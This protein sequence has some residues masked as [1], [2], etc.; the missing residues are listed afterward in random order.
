LEGNRFDAESAE[1]G[2][3]NKAK[4]LRCTHSKVL[5]KGAKTNYAQASEN[6]HSTKFEA[7]A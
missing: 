6:T 4:K 7:S 3:R 1:K 2:R 5:V